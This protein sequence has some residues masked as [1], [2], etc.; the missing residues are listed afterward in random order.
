LNLNQIQDRENPVF[1][2]SCGEK[3]FGGRGKKK[4]VFVSLEL[5]ELIDKRRMVSPPHCRKLLH[6]P[7]ESALT[8]KCLFIVIAVNHK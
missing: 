7:N 4:Y 1:S 8:K 6:V 3:L 2:P 5:G